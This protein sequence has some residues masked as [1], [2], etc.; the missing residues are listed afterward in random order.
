M[1]F[2]CK[3]HQRQASF[4]CVQCCTLDPS[5]PNFELPPREKKEHFFRS[6]HTQICDKNLMKDYLLCPECLNDSIHSDHT[7]KKLDI[8]LSKS[9]EDWGGITMEYMQ[10]QT[11]FLKMREFIN[12]KVDKFEFQNAFKSTV[13]DHF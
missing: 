4:V 12:R 9:K 8:L 5:L 3:K 11:N 2:A 13:C 6:L 1:F 10:N 7:F